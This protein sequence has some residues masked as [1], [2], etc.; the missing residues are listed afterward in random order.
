MCVRYGENYIEMGGYD[1]I[2]P[3]P[4]MVCWLYRGIPVD[5][6]WFCWAKALIWVC[7]LMYED[8]H[9]R[10]NSIFYLEEPCM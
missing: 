2:S 3:Q 8:L 4:C 5:L 1:V 10:T 9:V 7:N 6:P